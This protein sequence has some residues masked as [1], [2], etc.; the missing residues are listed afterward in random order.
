MAVDTTCNPACA[1]NEVCIDG[2]CNYKGVP[3]SFYDSTKTIPIFCGKD[4]VCLS[5]KCYKNC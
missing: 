5:E 3:C 1:E 4:E 2:E